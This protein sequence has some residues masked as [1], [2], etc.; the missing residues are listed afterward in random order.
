MATAGSTAPPFVK[1]LDLC[2][3]LYEQAVAPVLAAAFP[4]MPYS[5]ALLGH[6]SDVLGFDTPQSMD[7]DW[8]PR[9]LLFLNET[10]YGSRREE[11]DRV[12]REQLPPEILGYSTHYEGHEDG[13]T[14]M[15]PHAGGPVNHR[16]TTHT[17]R[18][19][20]Q[21]YMRYD[22]DRP[23][24][25]EDWLTF[26]EQFL[27]GIASGRVFHDGLG[28]LDAIRATLSDYPHF[29]WLYVLAAHWRRISQEEAFVGRCAQVGDE[30]GSRLIAARLVRDL[31]RLCFT[32]ERQYAPYIKW[33]GTAFA[34]LDCAERLGPILTRALDAGSWPE[35]ETH[36]TAAY[37]VVAAMHNG[38]GI[39]APLSTEVSP[40]HDRPFLV[41]HAERFDAAIRGA[42]ADERVRALPPGI[43]AID[44]VVD[45]TDVLTRPGC[46]DAL[47]PLYL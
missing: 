21:H 46:L 33:L 4:D 10:D 11:I 30:L 39:T 32:M 20:F 34:Q 44:Q 19:F 26:P 25:A 3:A 31:I 15:A 12:L 47:R 6:G 29:I 40:F 9:G 27:R 37:E 22:P 5:A 14:V 23:L 24:Q 43:G 42:I 35:R 36:L 2:Q 41:L 17:V 7:H 28:R 13:T 45:S 8:G 38:L 18:G 1:G 16:I